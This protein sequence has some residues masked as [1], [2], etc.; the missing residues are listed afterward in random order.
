MKTILNNPHI[1]FVIAVP[2]LLLLGMYLDPLVDFNIYDTYYVVD[3]S[4][5]AIVCGF[6]A[7][8]YW[9]ISRTG[10]KFSHWLSGIHI[11]VCFG[12]PLLAFLVAQLKGSDYDITKIKYYEALDTINFVVLLTILVGQLVFPI[13]VVYALISYSKKE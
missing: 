7:L 3:S 12:L 8:F 6:Y 13:N 11:I 1:A 2:V 10:R 5:V 4:T 9:F